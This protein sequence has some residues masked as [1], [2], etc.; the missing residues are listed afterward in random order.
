MWRKSFEI[1]YSDTIHHNVLVKMTRQKN[2]N[3]IE[4]R[5]RLTD[6]SFAVGKQAS[7]IN[8]KCFKQVKIIKIN[9]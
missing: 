7:Y 2:N 9:D 5:N 4:E 8:C 3:N 6:K 1:I